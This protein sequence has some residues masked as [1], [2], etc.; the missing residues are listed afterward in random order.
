MNIGV[1][2]LREH[3]PSLTRIHY[4]ITDTGG[5]APATVQ[6]YAEA[7][8]LMRACSSIS[9]QSIGSRFGGQDHSTVVHAIKSVKKEMETDAAFARLIEGLK[10]SIHD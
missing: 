1:Q 4:A 5:F 7:M 3:I 2:F 10:N 8:Y 6:P 9:L